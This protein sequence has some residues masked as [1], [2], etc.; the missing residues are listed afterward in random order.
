MYVPIRYGVAMAL[1]GN[2]LSSASFAQPSS[3]EDASAPHE[4]EALEEILVTANPL[5]RETADL[6]QSATVL[7]GEALR[8]QLANSLGETLARTPGLSNASF[9][10]NVGRPVIRGLQG[11]RVGI[12]SNSLAVS[13]ASSV[14]QDHAV[15]VEPFLADQIEVLRGPSTLLFGSG[16]IGGVV[17]IVSPSI[18]QEIPEQGYSGRV[19][20][21]ANTAAN[22]EFLA[23]RLDLGEASFAIHADGFHRRSNDYDIPGRAALYASAENLP[24]EA[25]AGVL[26]NSFLNNEG[27]TLG[28]SRIGEQWRFGASYTEYKSNYG[29]P[30]EEDAE[31]AG[32]A[33]AEA[34]SVHVSIHLRSQRTEAELVGQDPFAGFEMLKLRLVDNAYKHTEYEGAE[35]GTVFA[36]DSN[37]TRLELKHKPW[38]AW[39]GVFGVQYT[40]LDFSAVG[41]EA[42]VPTSNTRTGAI[43]WIERGDFGDWQLDLGLRYDD[44]RTRV[45]NTLVAQQGDSG[46]SAAA[47]F[48]PFS[49]STG[50]VWTMNETF[51]FFGSVSYAERAPGVDELFANGPHVATRVFEVGDASLGNESSAHVEGGARLEVGRLSG[52]ATV[53]ADQFDNYIYQTNSGL[54]ADGLPVLYWAQRDAEF[55][56]AEAELRYDFEVNRSGHWQ[57][58]TFGDIVDGELDD[59]AKVP[60]QPP[61][62]IALG[63]DWDAQNWSANLLWI[64]AYQQNNVA[65]A[66]TETPGYDLLNAELVFS[67]AAFE[68]FEWQVYLKGQNLLDE[69]IR[70]STSYLK[71]QAPQI[72]RNV[73]FG[74]RAYF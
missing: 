33:D 7:Q 25:N 23:G 14:S 73:I 49:A 37:N 11:T 2:L 47:D 15:A 3:T 17:N 12:L 6:S 36:S 57:L 29:I 63:L 66:E 22:E 19:T 67:R 60:L 44:V 31:E 64:H 1:L 51:D 54:E 4:H 9:G 53:Y 24:D 21:Q 46:S 69:D 52:S 62:R 74:L 55:I 39:Q 70:N 35:V 30:G 41:A 32:G 59:N 5:S 27:G 42:F 16:A 8:Q 71:D 56:G 43:F 13:D 28:A 40:D 34:E 26:V 48:Q 58:F 72:G 45:P 68:R 38:G 20:T 65:P 10:E 18:P 61:R 50:L